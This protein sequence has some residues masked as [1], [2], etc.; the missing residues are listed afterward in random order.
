[1]DIIQ[2]QIDTG[3]GLILGLIIGYTIQHWLVVLFL[4]LVLILWGYFPPTK[5]TLTKKMT[6]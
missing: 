5:N 1:M 4:F 3:T 6:E 2:R